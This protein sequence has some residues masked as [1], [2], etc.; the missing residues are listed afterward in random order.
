VDLAEITVENLGPAALH[1]MPC[2]VCREKPAV[3]DLSRGLMEPCWTCQERGWE[4][5]RRRWK[6]WPWRLPPVLSW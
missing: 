5:R 2:A 3:L 4:T 1:N 6:W